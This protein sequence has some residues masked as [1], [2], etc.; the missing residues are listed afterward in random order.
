ME[1]ENLK[2]I[3][4]NNIKNFKRILYLDGGLF[5]GRYKRGYGYFHIDWLSL[6]L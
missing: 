1:L 2:R 6:Q 4:K 3:K 5:K